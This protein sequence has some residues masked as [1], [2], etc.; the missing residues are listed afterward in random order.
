MNFMC[1]F[2][3]CFRWTP[4]AVI[5]F[6]LL[7]ISTLRL[8]AELHYPLDQSNFSINGD[9]SVQLIRVTIYQLEA[10]Q[11]TRVYGGLKPEL[12]SETIAD[13]EG[14]ISAVEKGKPTPDREYVYFYN[15][16]QAA[17]RTGDGP[18]RRT[19]NPLPVEHFLGG[20][21]FAANRF[22][23]S[24]RDA[25]LLDSRNSSLHNVAELLSGKVSLPPDR[26]IEYTAKE[27]VMLGDRPEAVMTPVHTRLHISSDGT[28]IL[29]AEFQIN[30]RLTAGIINKRHSSQPPSDLLSLEMDKLQRRAAVQSVPIT[31]LKDPGGGK[32]GLGISTMAG[33]NSY[34]FLV[35]Y[36]RPQSIAE[37]MGFREFQTIEKVNGAEVK[38]RTIS[39]L[40]EIL[41]ESADGLV[42]E[43]TDDKGTVMKLKYE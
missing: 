24:I 31:K 19:E 7:A 4:L 37:K 11:H 6:L 34:P 16:D 26:I 20:Y 10:I 15:R 39:E 21:D 43:V 13:L 35:T 32:L 9:G 27:A 25:Q 22:K 8:R 18:W 42:V 5:S 14:L 29:S 1:I 33:T 40:K 36:V 41:S 38:N 17:V 3:L 30:G 2:R 12:P 28:E 23:D